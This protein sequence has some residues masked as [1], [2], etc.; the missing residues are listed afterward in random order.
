MICK[1]VPFALSHITAR[2]CFVEKA[3]RLR[4]GTTSREGR[5]EMCSGGVWGTVCDDG[6]DTSDARVVCRQLGYSTTGMLLYLNLTSRTC[7]PT[8]LQCNTCSNYC[9]N[10]CPSLLICTLWSWNWS[11]LG[12]ISSLHWTRD[13]SGQLHPFHPLLLP[14]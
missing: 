13:S 14:L 4:G 11:N 8:S 3:I 9:F 12:F 10:R 7:K 1:L 5:V 6:W 2:N